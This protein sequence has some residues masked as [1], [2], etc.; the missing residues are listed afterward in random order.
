MVQIRSFRSAD[1]ERC[2]ML[3]ITI[4][5]EDPWHDQWLSFARARA[6]LADIIGTPGFRGFVAEEDGHLVALCF[7]HKRRW[8][9]GDEYF[10]NELGVLPGRQRKGIGSQL[11]RYVRE[12]LR[13]EGV[14]YISLLTERGIPAEQF[15]L[16]EGFQKSK[17]VI[18][19][20]QYLEPIEAD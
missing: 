15:Y 12:Q 10:I 2:V 3:F 13:Q 14:Q 8:W 11:L 7:G 16:K 20:Y 18:Y 1:L 6:F 17:D 19:M 5:S 4:F 9:Q